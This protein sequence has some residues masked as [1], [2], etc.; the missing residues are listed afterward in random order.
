MRLGLAAAA[1][2]A[3][4][5]RLFAKSSA[6]FDE[7]M[8]VFLADIHAG[9]GKRCGAAR[10]M[11]AV[12]VAEI[13]KMDPLP[14]NVLVFGYV[15]HMCGLAADYGISRQHFNLLEDAGITVTIGMGNHDRRSEFAKR[16]PEAAAK[17]LV[18]GLYVHLAETPNVDFLMLDT[19]AGADG[20]PPADE[21][22]QGGVLPE[23]EQAFL[24]S[25]LSVRGKPAIVCAHNPSSDLWC[26]GSRLDALLRASPRAA[27]YVHGHFHRWRLESGREICLPSAAS[28]GD[29][30]YAICRC[31]PDRA[32]IGCVL[33]GF[34][35]PAPA[36]NPLM[37][38]ARPAER[39]ATFAFEQP[40]GRRAG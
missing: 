21:G 15:A 40:P 11:F 38:P 30:G 33:K 36:G 23:N 9:A 28:W 25:F 5:R 14:R 26:C 3:A 18:P 19:L 2:L 31:R 7:N 34:S 1:C 12:T 17:S 16:W 4:P 6:D 27:G 39:A 29:V 37:L 20:R 10:K 22:P 8:A 35:L 24:R 32:E 13:L